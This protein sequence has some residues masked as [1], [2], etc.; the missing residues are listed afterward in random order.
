MAAFQSFEAVH[1]RGVRLHVIIREGMTFSSSDIVNAPNHRQ[2]NK[3]KI[4]RGPNL[5]SVSCLKSFE[6]ESQVKFQVIVCAT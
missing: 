6:F 2:I 1:T 3:I 4:V 5:E